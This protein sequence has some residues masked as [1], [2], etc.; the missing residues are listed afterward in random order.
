MTALRGGAERLATL[1]TRDELATNRLFGLDVHMDRPE[2]FEIA[3][4][5]VE[6]RFAG[7]LDV[8]INNAGYGALGPIE[9]QSEAEIRRQMEV[10][11]VGPMLLTNALLP[12]LR[13]AQGRILN[14]SGAVGYIAFPFYALYCASKY[15]LEGYTESLAY[16]LKPFGVQVGI[17]EPGGFRTGFTETAAQSSELVREGSPYKPRAEAMTNFLRTEAVKMNGDPLVVA[18]ALKRLC[19]Q[20]RVPMRTKVGAD[21]VALSTLSWLVPTRAKMWLIDTAMSRT[22]FGA[23]S[24]PKGLK[25]ADVAAQGTH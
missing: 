22:L 4:A 21:A 10:N 18:K 11:C 6:E 13:L 1:F 17:V 12:A 7:R 19:V 16:D 2:T 3:R 24:A 25:S 14:V 5:F 20:R 23:A 9:E 8:L 15:A